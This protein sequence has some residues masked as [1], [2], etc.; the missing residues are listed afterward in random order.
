MVN[1]NLKSEQINSLLGKWYTK[2][3]S[4]KLSLSPKRGIFTSEMMLEDMAI[5]L[6][7]PQFEPLVYEFSMEERKKSISEYEFGEE[8]FNEFYTSVINYKF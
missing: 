5:R 6:G 4:N 8:L 7:N 2:H 1:F 3:Y